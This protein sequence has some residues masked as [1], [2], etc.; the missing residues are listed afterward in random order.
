MSDEPIK[1][2][3][4]KRRGISSPEAR[5]P[6]LV[7]VT[8]L[9]IV[10]VGIFLTYGYL[11]PNTEVKISTGV[12]DASSVQVEADAKTSEVYKAAKRSENKQRYDQA[13]SKDGGVAIPFTFDEEPKAGEAGKD[14][15]NCGCTID[16][17]QL[18][19]AIRRI[20]LV[21]GDKSSRDLLRVEK[22]DIYISTSGQLMGENG[23]P[24]VFRS[25]PIHMDTTGALLDEKGIA[26]LTKDKEPL[27]L[28]SAG[29]MID[30]KTQKIPLL[31]DLTMSS[32]EL[33]M[34]DGRL[35]IRPGNMQR[36]ARS[37]IY[38]TSEGQL[39]TMD[40]KPIRHS[41]AYVYQ[42]DERKLLNRNAMDVA[43]EQQTVYQNTNGH[44]VNVSGQQFK[45]PGVLFS[46]EGIMIDNE[47]KL[48]RPLVNIEKIG[49]SDIF[50]TKSNY[51]VDGH[52]LPITHYGSEVRV[53]P[54][55]K[56]LTKSGQPVFNRSR[57]E[58]YLTEKGALR[59]DVGKGGIQSGVLKTSEGV[60][61]DRHAQMITRRG[62]LERRGMSDI[63]LTSDGLLSDKDG[64]PIMF[65]KKDTFLDFGSVQ[66]NGSQGLE[67][68]DRIKVTDQYGNRIF[69]TL[70]G[71]LVDS[72]G[73]A[74]KDVGILASS[75]GV[76]LTS[77]GKKIVEEQ[78]MERVV[79]KDGQPVTFNG[80]DV[81]KGKD[82]R[83]YDAD[84]NPILAPD[85]RAVFMDDNGN[86]VDETGRA[87]DNVDLMAG[88]RVVKNGELATR[89]KLTTN[90]GERILHN[91]KEV[92]V[93][94]SGRVIDADGNAVLTSDGREVYIDENG[95]LI[96]QNGN[97]VTE[98][99]LKTETGRAV[100][101]N[102]VAGREQVVTKNGKAVKFNGRDVF[103]G[104]DGALYDENGN[105][106]TTKDGRRV[107][108]DDE[109]NM[110]DESG[111]IVEEDLLTV[112]GERYVK[113]G[114]LLTRKQL[115]DSSGNSIQYQGKDVF[116]SDDGKLVDENGVSIRTA[117]GRDVYVNKNGDLVD[118]DGNLITDD[119]LTTTTK[120]K[121]DNGKTEAVRQVTAADGTPLLF[122]G[123][124]VFSDDKGR[125]LDEDGNVIR[126][127]DGREVY[128][129]KNGNLVDKHGS[130][131][132]EKLLDKIEVRK[133]RDG[134]VSSISQLTD[135]NGQAVFYE[136][137][138]V[139]TDS[140]GRLVDENG[141]V[142]KT[143]DGR[144][145]FLD[146]EGNMVDKSGKKITEAILTDSSGKVISEGLKKGREKLIT[147]DGKTIKHNGKDVY[148]S[149]DGSLVDANGNQLLTE[150]GK[151]IYV[152]EQGNLVDEDGKR[153]N[154]QG[155]TAESIS[156]VNSGLKKG[157]EASLTTGGVT[158]IKQLTAN[159]GSPLTVDG[160]SVYVDEHGR[161]VD[162][163]GKVI[164]TSD[165]REVFI[166]KNGNL[167]DENGN[168]IDEDLLS[169]VETRGL[170]QGEISSVRQMT[171][172][173]GNAIFFDGKEVFQDSEGRLVDENGNAIT[174]ADGRDV[175][176][177]K[178]GN[179]VDKSGNRIKENLLTDV[180][181]ESISS[182]IKTGR[183]K[184][185]SKDGSAITYNGRDVFKAADG[186]LVDKDGNQ[187]LSAD[188]KKIF[189][190]ED[191]DL[192]DENGVIVTDDSFVVEERTFVKE[193]LKTGAE[194]V[195]TKDGKDLLFNG[196]KVFKDADGY[197]TDAQGRKI[198]T[199][200]GK[201]ILVDSKGRLVD[202]DGKLVDDPRFES[203]K[204]ENINSG[205]TAGL[206][207]ITTKDGKSV[208][209]KGNNVFKK[210]DGS[211]VD[212]SGNEITTSDGRK[213]YMNEDGELV[214][215]DGNII[216]EDLLTADSKP[217]TQG[218]LT[219]V[220][221]TEMKRV[222]D[223]DLF[224]SR[225]GTLL[226]ESGKAITFNGKKVKVGKNGQ[227]FDE[228]GNAVTDR[229][230]K[231][232]FINA[233]GELVDNKGELINDSLLAN[234]KGVLIDSSGKSVAKSIRQVGD[235]DIYQTE[236]G[237]LVDKEGKAIKFNGEDVYVGDDG[238]LY[239]ENGKPVTD[240]EG[241]SVYMDPTT[242]NIVDRNGNEIKGS[243]L[244]NSDGTLIDS[245][246]ELVNSGG[247]L[248]RIPGTDLYRTE[249]GQVVDSDGKPVQVNGEPVFVDDEGKLVNKY[250]NA[251][252]F[253][254]KEVY[255]SEDG[256]LVDRNGQPLI[257]DE[258]RAIHLSED[259]GFVN[260]D[261]ES[262]D[263]TTGKVGDKPKTNR[264]GFSKTVNGN[265]QK[266]T[267]NPAAAAKPKASEVSPPPKPGTSTGKKPNEQSGGIRLDA[268]SAER[269]QRRYA[270]IKAGMRNHVNQSLQVIGRDV[271][272]GYVGVGGTSTSGL[273]EQ[274]I[275]SLTGGGASQGN[276]ESKEGKPEN[277]V[278]YQKAGTMLYAVT[279]YQINSDFIKEVV[280]DIVGLPP[281]HPL[282]NS[283]AMGKFE[284]VYD[285]MVITFDK[286]CPKNAECVPMK[287]V[288][289]DP[290]TSA[291]AMAS[292]VDH[293]Y[294]YRYGGLFLSSLL[295]G[296][297]EAM[298]ESGTR[299]ESTSITGS[300][301]TTTGLDGDKLVLRSFGKVGERFA[302]A[303]A[304]NINRPATAWL[305]P[306]EEMAIML[307]DDI[308]GSDK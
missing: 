40:G 79:T 11:K 58:V 39:V 161:V 155:F 16:E 137:K 273:S 260:E 208:K 67:T 106:I 63:F 162:E 213:V 201:R 269:L 1:Q 61:L 286:V 271:N 51:L 95:N 117:D 57:A 9:V 280:V 44:L 35:A 166:D 204:T 38:V 190:N 160:K 12:V 102:I 140:S 21:S 27:Y 123:K 262:V 195:V 193:G 214:D 289:L 197:L 75:D 142:I 152:D 235:S 274:E 221:A 251:I 91:G 207:Q 50:R 127:S 306:G 203:V 36:V 194:K 232:V 163:D 226:D 284:L 241:N 55:Q 242:G 132:D 224:V 164:T 293:H 177:D 257:D 139:F 15:E 114:D 151:R 20:G 250:G 105:A 25:S 174:T 211:L 5:G 78:D 47:G 276:P 249:D 71:R 87:I 192:V 113:S 165:G 239:Y 215:I 98:E 247:K 125:L 90:N 295:E 52:G 154:D 294:W 65:N 133:V 128:M 110:V 29:E 285:R 184:L 7:G 8:I 261:G 85:G 13:Q 10:A 77:S 108:M 146:A 258:N 256:R 275:A 120:S 196:S 81:F 73:N 240:S 175:Y 282:Y 18:E 97:A 83:L 66:N 183:E 156:K 32:G 54:G 22:S 136:G 6:I 169:K 305:D 86:I 302:D 115:T 26:F 131:I 59:V 288:A 186:S 265:D 159:D 209:Y 277:S 150:D 129:D 147:K 243:V 144:D 279:S 116:I 245:S 205:F 60:A 143:S 158:S 176:V 37:D 41:G 299:E 100:S 69:L 180:T 234:G 88:E 124:E 109:G 307:F 237:R 130:I 297:S 42:N 104:H 181:G 268:A 101:S 206:D 233:K 74:V 220:P 266:P 111:N 103:K 308:L 45:Q 300:K 189:V 48:T 244:A 259:G 238:R 70:E 107:F 255:T 253:K 227:L 263:K 72:Q 198:L 202:E 126:T 219:S 223:T 3:T 212:E 267:V 19:D 303:F 248:K 122:N 80:K 118:E 2:K 119:L 171:D 62:R 236:D 225:D 24:L 179:L 292:D 99:L 30:R 298:S 172:S 28:S 296:T 200:D 93:D 138:E 46:Y 170:K 167:V 290:A 34:S 148:K 199:P 246:G 4:V 231:P 33:Y 173:N 301:V 187:I 229:N 168:R 216:S 84:G 149:K 92:F 96:D 14:I 121:F 89:K 145:I 185:V 31:G 287:G 43:W 112:A 53:G 217:V 134:E 56:L 135:A 76:L 218:Q 178:N 230:G 254:G 68:Y 210:A 82:G 272:P 49:N 23:K 283:S 182:G 94:S 64:K 153:V 291:A 157:K 188:G 191:G 270:M 141:N 281:K 264:S 278:V 17:K 304:D 222:G 228:N 252:K